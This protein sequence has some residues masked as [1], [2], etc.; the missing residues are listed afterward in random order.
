M[1]VSGYIRALAVYLWGKNTRYPL[2]RRLGGPQSQ[3]YRFWDPTILL[4]NENLG[5]FHGVKAAT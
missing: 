4:T 5:I 1:E 2:N 3:P